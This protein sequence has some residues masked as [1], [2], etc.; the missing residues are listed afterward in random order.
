MLQHL[1]K[2]HPHVLPQDLKHAGLKVELAAPGVL[3]IDSGFSLGPSSE[4]ASQTSTSPAV[5]PLEAMWAPKMGAAEV[6]RSQ[7]LLVYACLCNGWKN[8]AGTNTLAICAQQA[9]TKTK[10][11]SPI[12]LP[13]AIQRNLSDCSNRN[14]HPWN[15]LFNMPLPFALCKSPD[16]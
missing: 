5:P 16:S 14:S 3:K 15:V 4:C 13:S 12:W 11:N 10:I 1:R 7:V 2:V 9:E 6:S 8:H